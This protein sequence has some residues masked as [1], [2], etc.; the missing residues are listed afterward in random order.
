MIKLLLVAANLFC[1][2]VNGTVMIHTYPNPRFLGLALCV[3]M[4]ASAIWFL[5][6]TSDFLSD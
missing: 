2:L 5:I 3:L 4:N 6:K 1:I